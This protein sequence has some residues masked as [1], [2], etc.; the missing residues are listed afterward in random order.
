[1]RRILI[2]ILLLLTITPTH[3]AP[4]ANVRVVGYFA[5]WNGTVANMQFD[6]L[7]HVIY[8]FAYPTSTGGIEPVNN[9]KLTELANAARANN[10]KV[11]ISF[12]GNG[13]FKS[14]TAQPS[15]I[16]TFVNNVAALCDQYQLDGVD[17][18]W[19]HPDPAN[20][21]DVRYVDLIKA[22]SAKLHSQN[23]L[24]TAAVMPKGYY[25]NAILNGVF[26]HV[27]WLNVM[28]YNNPWQ[29]HA[30]YNFAV[31]SL[32][33]WRD[34]GLPASK[35]VLGIPFYSYYAEGKTV[36]Y[37][38]LVAQNPLAACSDTM[39]YNGVQVNYNGFR[40]VKAKTRL[41]QERGLAGVMI[42]HLGHDT[43]DDTA[44]IRAIHAQIT[45]NTDGM[46]ICRYAFQPLIVTED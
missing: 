8:A 13:A 29:D 17:I 10:V 42:W 28:V 40:G 35:T 19:E 36:M 18:D 46:L 33:Y 4:A 6:K 39:D 41:A 45:G 34:R 31:E 7:T 26:D 37:R 3:A 25:A 9:A 16:T 1:M 15:T 5:S 30:S 14:L 24:L 23:R 11:L 43:A 2:L 20:G 44:L 27:D 38:E 22:L 12:A 32:N 21:T